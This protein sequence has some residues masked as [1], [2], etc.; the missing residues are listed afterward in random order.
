[1]PVN[2]TP[3]QG[4]YLQGK[5]G[6]KRA[7]IWL[8]DEWASGLAEGALMLVKKVCRV[9]G[10]AV[11]AFLIAA[12]Q[13][14]AADGRPA[15]SV[16]PAIRACGFDLSGADLSKRPGDDFFQYSNGVWYDHAVIPP[17]RS[18]I[19]VSRDL[20][21]TAETRIREIL[22]RGE[23]GVPLP[24][25]V[26]GVRLGSF[27]LA[28]MDEARAEVLDFEPIA[29]LLKMIRAV[30]TRE[31]LAEL[32]GTS[33]HSLFNSVFS[34]SIDPDDTAPGQYAVSIGQG[35]LG[36]DRAYYVT[37]QLADK[38]SAY[39]A[40]VTQVLTMIG[41]EAPERSAAAVLSFE[42]SVAKV[43]WT[44]RKR[45]DPE[46]TYN[47][48][49]IRALAKNTPFPWRRFL[50]SAD[51]DSLNRV[52]MA[53][54]SAIPKIAAVYARTSLE[55]LKAWQSFHLTNTAAPY[56]SKRFVSAH[57]AFHER[58][59]NGVAE[60]PERWKQAVG[61]IE[62]VMGSAIGRI[63]V[64]RYLSSEAKAQVA[65]LVAHLRFALKTRIE[66]LDWMSWE[67][68]LKALDKLAR[69]KLKIAYPE[70]WHDYSALEV[71]PND[72]MGNVQASLK[73]D[74]L[75]QVSR[76]HSPV[77]REEWDMNP[78]TVDAYY[79]TNLNEMVLPAGILQPPFFDAA[80]DPAI[81]YGGIGAIIGHEMIHGFDDQGRKY[82]GAGVLSNW[83]KS[84]DAKQFKVRAAVLGRQFD[85]YKP[86]AGAHVNG[87]LTMGEN[88]AD[89]GGALVALDAY[90]HL[91]GE[92]PA[93]E[94]DGLTGDQ[95]FFSSYA[96][97]WREKS[98]DASIRQQ[99]ISDSHAPAR[100]RVNGVVRNMDAWYK[101]FDVKPGDR[102][103]LAPKNRVRIW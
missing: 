51:L 59:M 94:I 42:T 18:S 28:F 38:K 6:T 46:K 16:P 37:P 35:D 34:L 65:D 73:F 3:R 82:D 64:E 1:M 63:Y 29:Q 86:F 88:I 62:A 22:E 25:R 78:Q 69:L 2:H 99:I 48:V 23:N 36:L 33:S 17:D 101:A 72:L 90:H 55:T 5:R 47:P 83:W 75:R 15:G 11:L 4:T 89:L 87:D 74:W 58:T 66:R 61:T 53:E 84:A 71:R 57:F 41:W 39:L 32:M 20:S 9:L 52:V 80:A 68:K 40:Y 79:D 100:Y 13:S 93:P 14:V 10:L 81:N 98:T 12:V 67:T 31:D 76:L 43:S 95:R 7:A 44:N 70:K 91:L 60:Q 77:D 21:I 30:G 92:T 102:L 19:G 27:Y 54:K 97:S 85:A 49:S 96:Q 56:L 50:A 103:F 45:R 8:H 24:A 26:D